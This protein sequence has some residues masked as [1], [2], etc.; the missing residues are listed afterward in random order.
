MKTSEEFRDSIYEKHGVKL[1]VRKRRRRQA[2]VCIPLAFLLVLGSVFLPQVLTGANLPF[3]RSGRIPLMLQ[4]GRPSD[5]TESEFADDLIAKI[6][7]LAQKRQEL[8]DELEALTAEQEDAARKAVEEMEKEADDLRAKVQ[9]ERE[10]D[11]VFSDAVNQFARDSAVLLSENFEENACYSPLSMYYALA[12]SSCGARG[13]TKYEFQDVLH[14]ETEW[15]AGMGGWTA[16]QCGNYYRQHYHEDET[17]TFRLENSLWLDGRFAFGDK[18]ISYAENDFY[19]SLFQVDFSDP[20]LGDEMT[21]WVSD[22]TDGQLS[23]AFTF[24]ENQMLYLMNTVLYEAE[25]NYRFSPKNNTQDE[26][27]KADGSTVTAEFMNRDYSADRYY[28]GNGFVSASLPLKSHDRMVFVLPD[29]G[30]STEELLSDPALFEEMFLSRPDSENNMALVRW[31]IPKFD[32]TC[33]YDMRG[34]LMGLGLERA[35]DPVLADFTGMGEKL[36]MYL[37]ETMQNVRISVNEDGV[38]AAAYTEMVFDETAIYAEKAVDMV[39]DRPFLFA[40]LSNDV[41]AEDDNAE[42]VV[43]VGVCGDP[44]ASGTGSA[45]A[46][47]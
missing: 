34:T 24:E 41:T 37:A 10:I 28:E 13:Q 25:W 42:T 12:L 43:F 44:T 5:P 4:V 14:A 20:D 38:T 29:P 17:S 1:A 30:V 23:P 2:M 6:D 31:S 22:Q 40:I 9:G 26:F 3:A 33:E 27:H 35:F 21:K 45:A 36:E 47:S 18:F 32:F 19:S 8:M 39:L 16:K 7:E 46:A 15:E 11:P